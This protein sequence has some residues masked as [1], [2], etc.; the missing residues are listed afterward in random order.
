MSDSDSVLEDLVEA[1]EDGDS[2][3]VDSLL[4]D[5]S[6]VANARLPLTHSPPALVCA[7]GLG[8]KDVVDV[9]LRF[10]ARIDDTDDEGSTACH[11]AA[12]GRADVLASL[13]VRGPNLALKCRLGNTPLDNSFI[14]GD[15]RISMMLIEAGAPL[16][17][18]NQFNLCGLATSTSAI[19]TLRR[20]GVVVSELRNFLGYTPLHRIASVFSPDDDQTALLNMLV[21]EC[22]VDLDAS[23]NL[24]N[25]CTHVAQMHANA[26]AMRFFIEAGANVN[27]VD[28]SNRTPLHVMPS[29]GKK[30]TILLLAAGADVHARDDFGQ[31]PCIVAASHFT[32]ERLIVNV[33]L[34]AGA[35]LDAVDRN[36]KTAR[37]LLA[38]H[39]LTF[40]DDAKII[41][42]ARREIVKVRLD[43]VRHRAWQVCIG[44]QSRGLDALQMCEILLF[45]CG[46]LAPVVA[47]F[48]WWKIAT[49]V[50]HFKNKLTE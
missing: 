38:E 32:R 29:Y 39:Q 49:T 40:D 50:K 24:G 27:A 35:D 36:G 16:E 2:C 22:K 46:P 42:S 37:Q 47:F 33:M 3:L 45:A 21:N 15:R 1:I 30:T 44:L 8:Q 11:F 17:H 4:S 12:C 26:D 28:R 7:A 6:I 5:G 34:A 18:V 14:H 48:H 20:R 23:D 43:F 41:D 31:T 9:L 19:Q 25:T 10:G 13:L